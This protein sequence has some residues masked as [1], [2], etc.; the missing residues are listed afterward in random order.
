MLVRPTIT[1]P[2]RFRRATATASEL[3]GGASAS[4]REPARVGWPS[5]S[6]RSLTDTGMP[7]SGDST[8]P[9]RAQTVVRVGGG[10]GA[11]GI[12]FDEGGRRPGR[13]DRRSVRARFRRARGSSC[14]RRRGRR[15]VGRAAGIAANG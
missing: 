8:V 1:A 10:A 13:P 6:N 4:T 2:A 3:A 7:A 12:D 5:I 9:A 11:V 14:V 15:R